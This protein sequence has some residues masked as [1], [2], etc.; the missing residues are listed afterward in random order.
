MII[1]I[2]HFYSNHLDVQVLF[3]ASTQSSAASWAELPYYESYVHPSNSSW[4][5][6]IF[7]F[8]AVP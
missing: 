4:I 1:S 8:I 5:W 2:N 7:G 3:W 6:A